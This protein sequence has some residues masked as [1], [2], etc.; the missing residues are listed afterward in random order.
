MT[1]W[2]YQ[3]LII[4]LNDLKPGTNKIDLIFFKWENIKFKYI[5]DCTTL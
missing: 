2:F 5:A 4:F 1:Q 3:V